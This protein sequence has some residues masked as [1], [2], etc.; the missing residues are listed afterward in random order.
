MGSW[1]WRKL[2][3]IWN[4]V[5]HFISVDIRDG[6]LVFSGLILDWHGKID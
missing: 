1:I 3:K 4:Q 5:A 6:K 2:L